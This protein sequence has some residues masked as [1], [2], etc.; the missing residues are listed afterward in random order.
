MSNMQ[1]LLGSTKYTTKTPNFEHL[2]GTGGP[3]DLFGLLFLGL[4][5]RG[6][7]VGRGQAHAL[8][9]ICLPVHD[10]EFSKVLKD[11]DATQCVK[12]EEMGSRMGTI[13]CW[14]E[15]MEAESK[16][17]SQQ[18]DKLSKTTSPGATYKFAPF[19]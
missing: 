6:T 7:F 1:K 16:E 4:L 2:E 3:L 8:G 5:Q 12:F 14:K 17:M 9:E 19:T 13:E 18:I 15:K 10:Q 11:Y